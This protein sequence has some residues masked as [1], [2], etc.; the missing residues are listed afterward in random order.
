[1][2]ESTLRAAIKARLETHG[3]SIGRVHDY[4]R[5]AVNVKDFLGMFQ[6]PETKKIFGWEI[7]RRSFRVV[8]AG[9]NKW[10]VIHHFLIRGYYG[11]EDAAATEKAVNAL[12]DTIMLD[13]TRTKIDGTQGEQL[14]QGKVEQ[15]MFGSVLCHRAEIEL[16][17]VAEIV[18]RLPEDDETDLLMVGLNYYLTP[19]DDEID[20]SDEVTL[21]G[22]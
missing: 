10:K 21:E 20:A 22:L 1:M 4:E 12:V 19:G 16:P 5:L 9:M 18:A 2:S 15:W 7:T 17:E 13:F 6:D 14:P 11:I 8:K 3:A